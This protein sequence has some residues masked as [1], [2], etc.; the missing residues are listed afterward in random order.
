MQTANARELPDRQ[1]NYTWRPGEE[2]LVNAIIGAAWHNQ[3]SQRSGLRPTLSRVLSRMLF[4][5]RR[6]F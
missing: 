5:G 1:S 6:D 3:M 2:A 4:R